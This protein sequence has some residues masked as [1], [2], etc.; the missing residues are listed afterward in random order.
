MPI[1]YR[2]L[3]ATDSIPEITALLH[4]S[5]GVLAAR[6]MKFLASHQSDA[7]T[8]ERLHGGEAWVAL[9]GARIVGTVTV[10]RA[11]ADHPW[12]MRP[13]VASMEQL[14]VE[15]ELQRHGIGSAL[16]TLA[17]DV[18]RGWGRTEMALD[19]S[20]RADDLIALYTKRGYRVV[21][22]V[23]RTIVNYGSIVLSKTLA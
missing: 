6:G 12:Y 23:H 5:Y 3:A 14:A 21:G 17:E 1:T 9:D 18:G 13:E 22:D 2:K 10:R 20:E 16:I 7:I 4:R 15:P 19:T 8:R 11:C